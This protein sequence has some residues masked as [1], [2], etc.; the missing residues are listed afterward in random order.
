MGR[1]MGRETGN[2]RRRRRGMG[3][4]RENQSRDGSSRFGITA[5]DRRFRDDF[6]SGAVPPAE[7]GHRAHVRLAYI[8][9]A[10]HGVDGA[11]ARMRAAL[12]GYLAHHGIDAAKFHETMTRAWLL[13]VRH[14]M[15]RSPGA[16]G[17]DPFID[18][19]PALLDGSI[20]LTHYSAELLFSPAARARFVE[21]DLDPIPRQND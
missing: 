3:M 2:D 6:E 5:G 21:P 4:D 17:A 12:L 16:A 7:F 9:L 14:F 10:E 15:H 13:A 19:N 11:T 8:Y 1:G 18:A 20:M